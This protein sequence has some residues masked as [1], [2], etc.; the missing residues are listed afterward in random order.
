M[1]VKVE[2]RNSGH[3]WY[4]KIIISSRLG[5]RVVVLDLTNTWGGI[6]PLVEYRL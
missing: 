1:E 6:G 2:K 5:D 4:H 3:C